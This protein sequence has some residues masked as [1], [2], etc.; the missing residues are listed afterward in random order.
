MLMNIMN[1][2]V[3]SMSSLRLTQICHLRSSSKL[4]MKHLIASLSFCLFHALHL[5]FSLRSCAFMLLVVK[6]GHEMNADAIVESLFGLFL[7]AMVSIPCFLKSVLKLEHRSS[8]SSP[9]LKLCISLRK[10]LL[11]AS[12]DQQQLLRCLIA[13][14]L[15][16]E[17]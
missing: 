11:C 16:A 14:E 17:S 13:F 3:K 10:I 12:G 1:M 2:L 4:F 9:V 8:G 15:V 7:H 6:S 5:A